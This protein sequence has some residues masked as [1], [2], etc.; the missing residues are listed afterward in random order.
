MKDIVY[1]ARCASDLLAGVMMHDD[2]RVEVQETIA[3]LVR[4]RAEY[5]DGCRKA[6]EYLVSWHSFP[7]D[8]ATHR[9]RVAACLAQLLKDVVQ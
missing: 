9:E 8:A 5:L 4:E 2:T 3:Q 6:H 7:A 1:R